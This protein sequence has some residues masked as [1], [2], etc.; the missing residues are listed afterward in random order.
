MNLSFY[1][2]KPDVLSGSLR[3]SGAIV[4]GVHPFPQ[5]PLLAIAWKSSMLLTPALLVL[6]SG[7][8]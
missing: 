6:E 7:S 5:S 2:R 1:I 8:R 3:L 4:G